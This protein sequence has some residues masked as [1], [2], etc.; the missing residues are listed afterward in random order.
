[1][2][3]PID[4]SAFKVAFSTCPGEGCGWKIPAEITCGV[5]P[6]H[7]PPRYITIAFRCPNC[8][9]HFENKLDGAGGV[10]HPGRVVVGGRSS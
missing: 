5:P 6:G 10:P 1:M 8:G 4:P 7:P 9:G 3:G 2:N